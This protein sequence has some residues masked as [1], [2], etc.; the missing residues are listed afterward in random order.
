MLLLSL[1]RQLVPRLLAIIIK[2]P[3]LLLLYVVFH[4]PVFLRL[5]HN[6]AVVQTV[7]PVCCTSKRLHCLSSPVYV[8]N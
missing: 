4:L 5:H 7:L 3:I 8:I 1:S 2:G 6:T